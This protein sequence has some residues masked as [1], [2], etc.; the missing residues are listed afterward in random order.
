[1]DF[2]T[3]TKKEEPA[4]R[5][6]GGFSFFGGASKENEEEKPSFLAQLIGTSENLPDQKTTKQITTILN[7][8]QGYLQKDL[9]QTKKEE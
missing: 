6:S 8:M 5:V 3:Q 4:K 2:F 7:A 9:D 1:M